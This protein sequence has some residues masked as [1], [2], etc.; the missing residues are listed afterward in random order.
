MRATIQ[1]ALQSIFAGHGVDLTLDGHG[2]VA[3]GFSGDVIVTLEVPEHGERAYAYASVVRLL[4][5]EEAGAMRKALALNLFRMKQPDV[6]IALDNEAM[7]LTLCT[8]LR[9]ED[10]SADALARR[11]E[12][13]VE[14]IAAVRTALREGSEAEVISSLHSPLYRGDDA[15]VFRT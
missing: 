9:R 10:V 2:M 14:E 6:W 8:S 1:Q 3:L 5:G 11:L 15:I 7:S 13:F 4:A 12:G